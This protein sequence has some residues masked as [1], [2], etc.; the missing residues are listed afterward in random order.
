MYFQEIGKQ[1]G[2]LKSPLFSVISIKDMTNGF[3]KW[4]ENITTSPS[5]RHLGHY[6]VLLTFD[7]EKDKELEGFNSE[8][9]TIYNT[10]INASIHLGTIFTRCK[11]SIAVMIE[12][13]QGN[14]KI[15]K[16]RLINIYEVDYNLLLKHFWPHKVTNHAEQFNLLS[17]TQWSTRPMCS[18]EVVVLI[19]EFITEV[20]R[21]T[22]TPHEKIQNDAVAY[23]NR[24]VT[25]HATSFDYSKSLTSN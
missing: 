16:L 23:F 15:K 20:S 10:I 18:D 9:L 4:R 12:K 8:M 25:P 24:Q 5:S 1:S 2:T 6:K 13:I 3:K 11:K 17:E 14:T 19:D 21:M 22:C 7:D